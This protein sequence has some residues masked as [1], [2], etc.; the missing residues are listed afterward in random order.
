LREK[1]LSAIVDVERI[2]IAR[3]PPEAGSFRIEDG[4]LLVASSPVAKLVSQVQTTVAA[5]NS[6]DACL[7]Q[8]D[9]EQMLETVFLGFVLHELRHRTQGVELY[10]MVQEIKR[11][12]GPSAFS[13]FDVLADRDTA[14]AIAALPGHANRKDFLLAFRDALHLSLDHFFKVF[15]PGA[16]QEDKIARVIGVLLMTARLIGIDELLQVSEDRAL[17]LDA[18]LIAQLSIANKTLV[19]FRGEPSRQL[20]AVAN[21]RDD[22]ASLISDIEEGDFSEA[23]DWCIGLARRRGL[24]DLSL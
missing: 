15:P 2:R 13:E 17:P 11:A 22:L 6:E 12:G 23:L 20:V 7:G 3:L 5:A 16:N 19:I 10:G 9:F 21:D 1:F 4:E 8:A 18:P 14:Y 24:T